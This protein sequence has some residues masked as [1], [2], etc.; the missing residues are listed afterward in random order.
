MKFEHAKSYFW[1]SI[2]KPSILINLIFCFI[3]LYKFSLL[4]LQYMFAW[5]R[6]EATLIYTMSI[7]YFVLRFC[8][9]FF[10]TRSITYVIGINIYIYTRTC[11]QDGVEMWWNLFMDLL[12]H[13]RN[14]YRRILSADIKYYLSH[15]TKKIYTVEFVSL[16]RRALRDCVNFINFTFWIK[17]HFNV[18][19]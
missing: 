19:I 1:L 17:C 10:K 6:S 9:R 5:N 2:Y 4:I 12:A 11:V 8:E 13:E 7:T 15:I 18:G 3:F 14:G 16:R